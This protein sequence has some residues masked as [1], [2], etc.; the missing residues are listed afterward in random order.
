M[1]NTISKRTTMSVFHEQQSIELDGHRSRRQAMNATNPTKR[2][3]F[4]RRASEG[5]ASPGHRELA[6]CR[7]VLVH[8]L[9]AATQ[10]WRSVNSAS[11]K[12]VVRPLST[13]PKFQKN[14]L[15]M[16]N[17]GVIIRGGEEETDWDLGAD[18]DLAFDARCSGASQERGGRAHCQQV[19]R[20]ANRAEG[21]DVRLI[22]THAGAG[23]GCSA[24]GAACWTPWA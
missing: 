23:R 10:N 16:Q 11:E 22:R 9:I 13:R 3:D 24:R 15:E 6:I 18:G 21:N 4:G 1:G 17:D 19:I 2:R 8:M 5:L 7:G 20:V 14:A 12:G